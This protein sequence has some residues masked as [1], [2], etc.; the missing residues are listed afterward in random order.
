MKV[1][2]FAGPDNWACEKIFR[3]RYS[4]EEFRSVPATDDPEAFYLAVQAFAP[5]GL[6]LI[7]THGGPGSFLL[8]KG[9]EENARP[10]CDVGYEAGTRH[11]HPADSGRRIRPYL[12]PGCVIAMV[13]CSVA[14]GPLGRTFIMALSAGTGQTVIAADA[15]VVVETVGSETVNV[16]APGGRVW[17]TTDGSAPEEVGGRGGRFPAF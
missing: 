2:F 9:Q 16:K 3:R 7:G 13:S 11:T 8:I 17:R 14:A 5:V 4:G 12:A 6:L 10:G 1:L 15:N